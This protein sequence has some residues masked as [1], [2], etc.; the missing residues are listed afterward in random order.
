MHICIGRKIA[1]E[2]WKD[3]AVEASN[4]IT[5]YYVEK[6]AACFSAASNSLERQR[7]GG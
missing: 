5:F 2:V 7:D 6:A 4:S 3:E 1:K